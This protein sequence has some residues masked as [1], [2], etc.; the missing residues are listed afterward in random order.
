VIYSK[1]KNLC[2]TAGITIS[3]LEEKA[4]LGNGTVGGWRTAVPAVDTVKK[5]ADV[6]GV[7]VDSLLEGVDFPDRKREAR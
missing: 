4:G 5:V 2:E 7:S 1:I 6:L 3:K